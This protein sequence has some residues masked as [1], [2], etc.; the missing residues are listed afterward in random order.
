LAGDPTILGN[1]IHQTRRN[2]GFTMLLPI[3][4]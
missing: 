3:N 1:S 4:G 2:T